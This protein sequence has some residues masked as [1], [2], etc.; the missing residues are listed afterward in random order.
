[1]K[2]TLTPGEARRLALGA[3]GFGRALPETLPGTEEP[4]RPA[5]LP[6][7]RRIKA[8]I[9]RMGVLQID[10]VNVFS[11]SHYMP[12]FSRLGVYDTDLLDRQVLAP[13][14]GRKTPGF[15]EYLA[16]EATFTPAAD[17]PLWGFRRER[18]RQRYGHAES[19]FAANRR[20]VDWVRSELAARGPLRAGEIE[21]DAESGPRGPWWDWDEVKRALEMMWRF[22]DVV[23]AG[24]T[25]FERRYGLAEHVLPGRLLDAG[26]PAEQAIRTL[27]ERAARAQGVATL[28]DLADYYRMKRATV[29]TAVDELVEAGVLVPVRVRGWERGGKPIPA[30]RH[31]DSKVPRRIEAATLLTPF[32]PVV[33]FRERAHRMFDFDYRIEIYT[34]AAKR[35]F[36]YYSLPLLIGER[37][38][39]RIDLK[40]DRAGGRLLVQSAWWEPWALEAVGTARGGGPR[41]AAGPSGSEL[42]SRAAAAVVRAAAWQGLHEVSVSRWGDATDALAAELAALGPAQ[43]TV[44]RH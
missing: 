20:T 44:H 8:E 29:R 24:R 10:S 33:W 12:I 3:Q 23:I 7:A 22:G 32:D 31:R 19:W 27:V 26:V 42:A 38:A 30:W 25:G 6:G 13:V 28:S 4:S 11:R 43:G 39:G 9:A 41:G 37:I 40:A 35:R 21:R 2:D 14:A 1:M 18:M 36:G 16:H 17:W 15:I 34:P 5:A